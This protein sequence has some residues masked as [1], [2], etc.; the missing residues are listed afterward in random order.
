MLN[1][2]ALPA[3]AARGVQVPTHAR[4][5]APGVVHLGLGAFHRAHQAL[6]FEHLLDHGDGRWG[7]FGVAMHKRHVTDALRSQDGLYSVQLASTMGAR[8]QVCG[9]IGQ[10]SQQCEIHWCARGTRAATAR[11]QDF[12]VRLECHSLA[13]AQGRA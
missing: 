6:V 13:C 3:L 7:V 1:K 4:H 10:E 2:Q 9:A 11:Q 12:A 5:D 8:W